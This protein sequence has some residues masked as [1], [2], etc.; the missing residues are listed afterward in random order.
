[1]AIESYY[2]RKKIKY[3]LTTLK[4]FTAVTDIPN[5]KLDQYYSSV[6]IKIIEISSLIRKL[7]DLGKLP[8]GTLE[9]RYINVNRYK[10][11]GPDSQRAY[12]DMWKEYN[13]NEPKNDKLTLA[14]V[15]DLVIHSYVLQATG[16]GNYFFTD[17]F[18][19]SDWHRFSGLYLMNLQEFIIAGQEVVDK[20][21]YS[22]KSEY[23]PKLKKWIHKRF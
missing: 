21:P 14:Q 2:L 12:V 1:M 9:K 15:V 7:R 8:D 16:G 10:S 17:V 19:T 20:Y 5:E 4:K 13:L 6:E 18:I 3:H 11:N 22:I 23:N